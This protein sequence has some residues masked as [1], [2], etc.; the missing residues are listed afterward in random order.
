VFPAFGRGIVGL[1]EVSLDG[2]PDDPRRLRVVLDRDI[3]ASPQRLIG[4]GLI[5]NLLEAGMEVTG[6]D[7]V[8]FFHPIVRHGGE[9]GGHGMVVRDPEIRSGKLVEFDLKE[10]LVDAGAAFLADVHPA[11]EA[12]ESLVAGLRRFVHEA[13][14]IDE[15]ASGVGD[16]DAVAEYLD[17]GAV[18]GYGEVLMDQGVGDEFADGGGVARRRAQCL[19]LLHGQVGKELRKPCI[20]DLVWKSDA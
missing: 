3:E 8:G 20:Q 6:P 12:R 18:A 5:G 19:W 14:G 17:L 7:A 10:R 2:F 16:F 15:G 9:H 4:H 1:D 13:K 11:H